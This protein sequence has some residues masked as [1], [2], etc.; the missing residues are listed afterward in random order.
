MASRAVLVLVLAGCSSSA[1]PGDAGAALDTS[2]VDAASN[3]AGTD[4]ATIDAYR[5][6][7]DLTVDGDQLASNIQFVRMYFPP[8]SCELTEMCVTGSG[9]RT[10]LMFTTYTPNLGT[11]D[12]VLGSNTLPDGGTN[13]SF[14]YSSCHNH[15]HFRGYADYTLLNPDGS[16]AAQGHKQSFCVEDLEQVDHS[17]GI[18]RSPRYGNCGDGRSQQGISRGWA[19][20]YYPDLPCQWIDVTDVAPGTY[21]LNVAINTESTITELDYTNDSARA[22][23]VIPADYAAGPD[24]TTACGASDPYEGSGRNCGWYRE[25]VHTC[26]PGQHLSVGCNDRCGVG[27]CD[28]SGGGYDIRICRGDANCRGA[29]ATSLIAA[30]TGECGTGVFDLNSVCGVARFDCPSEGMY[31][32]LVSAEWTPEA[33]PLLGCHLATVVGP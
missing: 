4:T 28:L 15:Y 27:S 18:R 5:G 10:L 6:L 13:P 32:V 26:T 12:L 1:P 17:A 33:N 16:L 23:V 19:D 25:G 11:A 3:D 29:D 8:T 21:T 20:D 2:V 31:T 24:P 7:P 22:T 9:W 30:D 14:E